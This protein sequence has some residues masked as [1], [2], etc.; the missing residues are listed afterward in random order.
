MGHLRRTRYVQHHRNT[1]W[2]TV[3]EGYGHG[4]VI[5]VVGVTSHCS[6]RESRLQGEARQVIGCQDREVRE[7]RNAVADLN[8]IRAFVSK[9]VTGE[10]RDTEIGHA[11]F[12]GGPLEKCLLR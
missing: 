12:G 4:V 9:S 10:P 3:R 7:M 11:W 5:V 1:G 8:I 2:P 6:E